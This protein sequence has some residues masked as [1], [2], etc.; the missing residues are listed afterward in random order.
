MKT[1]NTTLNPVLTILEL[2]GQFLEKQ[3]VD[4]IRPYLHSNIV[5]A[6]DGMVGEEI[7][8]DRNVENPG[9]LFGLRA[10]IAHFK[11]KFQ[12][13]VNPLNIASYYVHPFERGGKHF[14]LLKTEKGEPKQMIM[15]VE[16]KE[17]KIYYLHLGLIS[18][19]WEFHSAKRKD[20]NI[21][22]FA[23][24]A[25]LQMDTVYDCIRK[26]ANINAVNENGE[27]LLTIASY[28]NKI[29]YQDLGW[30][31]YAKHYDHAFIEKVTSF[32]KQFQSLGYEFN[33]SVASF[34]LNLY[35]GGITWLPPGERVR[36]MMKLIAMGSDVN[37]F[38]SYPNR[39]EHGKTALYYAI[40]LRELDMVDFLVSKAAIVNLCFYPF[41]M[42]EDLVGMAENDLARMKEYDPRNRGEL[43]TLEVIIQR[44]KV[45]R[46]RT[47]SDTPEPNGHLEN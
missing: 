2:L 8:E 31:Y 36:I 39:K 35:T 27:T 44:L 18:T 16:F 20:L 23:A 9:V 17:S 38:K 37:K 12:A 21:Q 32:K 43:R 4:I 19:C 30:E 28:T 10:F 29:S 34:L 14:L 42:Y 25:K 15:Q 46:E 41:H 22:M 47:P 7:G 3:N 45:A 11:N 13:E 26:G 40:K 6:T 5:Y 1:K 33:D 24:M